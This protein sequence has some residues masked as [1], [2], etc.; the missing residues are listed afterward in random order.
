[1]LGEAEDAELQIDLLKKELK[2]QTKEYGVQCFLIDG[3]PRSA[4]HIA[5]W[6]DEKMHIKFNV[7][8]LGSFLELTSSV[9]IIITL[10]QVLGIIELDIP[11]EVAYSRVIARSSEQVA[12]KDDSK[13]VVKTF[14]SRLDDNPAVFAERLQYYQTHTVPLLNLFKESAPRSVKVINAQHSK[15]EVANDMVKVVK[16]FLRTQVKLDL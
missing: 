12:Q 16:D 10:L 15:R 3:F 13:D 2:H 4:A 11:D 7:C 5:E 6:T 14:P 8:A 1:M 9:I